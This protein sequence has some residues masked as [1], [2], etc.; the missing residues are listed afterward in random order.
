MC[1]G[2][3]HCSDFSDE[4]RCYNFEAI[5]L[6]PHSPP[7]VAPPFTSHYFPIIKELTGFSGRHRP[8]VQMERQGSS[9]CPDTHFQCPV[10]G[11]CLP[12]F[13]RCNH[14]LDCPSAKDEEGCDSYQCPGYFRCRASS[15][16]V[17]PS[18]VCDGIFHCPQQDDEL[19]C[20]L[21]CP[22]NCICGGLAFHCD[23]V[24]AASDFP[25]LRYLDASRTYM[26]PP[27][28]TRNLML[29]YLSLR[30][31]GLVSADHLGFPN[32]HVLDLCDNSISSVS[33][34]Q[35]KGWPNLR[36]LR[37]A[38]NPLK[39]NIIK[40][41][42]SY[43]LTSLIALDLSNLDVECFNATVLNQFINIR[44]LNL[45]NSGIRTLT[46]PFTTL[47]CLSVIDLRQCLINS[48]PDDVFEGLTSLTRVYSDDFKLC[49]PDVLP[50]DFNVNDCLS[51]SPILSSCQSL[52]G[53]GA[54]GTVQSILMFTTL[55]G[56]IVSFVLHILSKSPPSPSLH[57]LMINLTVSD[58]LVAIY[59]SVIRVADRQYDGRYFHY[60]VT[61]RQSAACK[62][63]GFVLLLSIIV[64]SMIVAVI[65]LHCALL[66]CFK[67]ASVALSSRG[68]AQLVCV[69]VWVMGVVL[70]AL[71]LLLIPPHGE[72]SLSQ[73]AL[74]MPLSAMTADSPNLQYEMSVLFLLFALSCFVCAANAVI[75]F[76]MKNDI[77]TAVSTTGPSPSL[78]C[79]RCLRLMSFVHAICRLSYTGTEML[80]FRHGALLKE[81]R[82][83]MILILVPSHSATDPL[84]YALSAAMERRRHEEN[85]RII[86]QLKATIARQR[87][88]L[89]Q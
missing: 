12:V 28:L 11:F 65:A 43:A 26:S 29:V 62:A 80:A 72:Q 52:V 78:T 51:P 89:K 66:L 81:T 15:V 40:D 22:N 83:G 79:A 8:S 47:S 84:M 74:C 41:T 76:A 88:H 27:L 69:V 24:F 4:D 46:D 18:H 63:A 31:C 16:C 37:L 33:Q 56:N 59:L 53:W 85:E 54:G 77:V 36:V 19:L 39:A 48:F 30:K 23:G 75:S 5:G 13:V 70:A 60:D 44:Y 14:A 86:K 57:V 38:G 25:D 10:A 67:S 6:S 49:C 68:G 42:S 45:S 55:A 2:Q 34:K 64:S 3:H 58:F 35:L 1:D 7:S 20:D 21:R 32:L 61:W 9:P 82:V 73:S 71:P 50:M 17:H 87:L